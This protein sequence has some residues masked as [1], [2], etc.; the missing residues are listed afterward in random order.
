MQDFLYDEKTNI[1]CIY[2]SINEILA[3]QM[4][5]TF[6]WPLEWA[7]IKCKYVKVSNKSP[8]V[9]LYMTTIVMFTLPVA[10]Y[11]IFTILVCMSSTWLSEWAKGR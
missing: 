4:Y 6:T 1:G 8:N 3:T 11:E 7:K 2:V 9:T 10:V 5:V